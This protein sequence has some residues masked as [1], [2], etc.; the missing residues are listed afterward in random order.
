MKHM[1]IYV[2]L[3]IGLTGCASWHWYGFRG[4]TPAQLERD[5]YECF[6]DTTQ[7]TAG[8]LATNSLAALFGRQAMYQR[9]MES[10]GYL[11]EYE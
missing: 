5:D 3:L 11:K 4:Q 10:K 2:L 9:C 7:V 8:E 1:A 6:R